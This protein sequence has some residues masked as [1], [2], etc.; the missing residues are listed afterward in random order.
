MEER[1]RRN[2]VH[3]ELTDRAFPKVV[4]CSIAIPIPASTNKADRTK[5][6]FPWRDCRTGT[7]VLVVATAGDV[8]ILSDVVH[9]F[10]EYALLLN[11]PL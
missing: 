9:R 2:I 6:L 4:F 11:I 7:I 1:T 8:D 10:D 3:D 5:L